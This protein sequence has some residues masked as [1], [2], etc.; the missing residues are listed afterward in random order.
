MWNWQGFGGVM[1]KLLDAWLEE[2]C[3]EMTV[4]L[5]IQQRG[6]GCTAN[7]EIRFR[8]T[9]ISG[10]EI[11]RRIAEFREALKRTTLGQY[12]LL[13]DRFVELWA[14]VREAFPMPSCPMRKR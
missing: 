4:A 13:F 6:E 10:A 11:E 3:R 8:A 9:G 2:E 1:G 7:G 12:L 14:A 5:T